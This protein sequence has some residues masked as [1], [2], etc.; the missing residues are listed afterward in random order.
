MSLPRLSPPVRGSRR[1]VFRRVSSLILLAAATT[2]ARADSTVEFPVIE[3]FDGRTN[4]TLTNDGWLIG[5]NATAVSDA[6]RLTQAVNAQAGTIIYDRAFS[7]SVGVNVQFDYYMGGGTGADGLAFFLIDGSATNPTP[8]GSGPAMGYA[9]YQ[10]SAGV[11]KGYLGVA[12]DLWGNFVSQDYF[13]DGL[14]AGVIPNSIAVR[15]PASLVPSGSSDNEYDYVV[16]S[17]V[18]YSVAGTKKVNL[19][20]KAD[21]TLSLRISGDN[22]T[23]W[24][25]IHDN[26]NFLATAAYSGYPL[27][28][29]FKLGFGASTGGSN[30]EHR[31]DNLVIR[32]PVDLRTTFTTAPSGTQVARTT[33]TYVIEATNLGPNADPA[34]TFA[35]TVPAHLTNVTWSAAYAGGASGAA[36][37]TGNTISQAINLPINGTATFTV[38]GTIADAAAGTTLNLSA[39]ATP[40]APFGDINDTNSTGTATTSVSPHPFVTDANISI[41]G[42][43]GTGGAYKIGDTV[44]AT[45]NNTAGGDNN[46]GITSVTVNFSAF[47]G[48]TTVAASNSSQT[49]TATYTLV[50]GAI[51]TTLANVSVTANNS[52]ISGTTTTADTTNAT[53]DTQAPIVSDGNLSI[54]GA[55]GTGGAYKI[56]DTV[57]ATWNNTA[58]GDNNADTISGVTVDFSAFGGGSAVAATSSSGT[59]TATYTLAAGAI[60][61][62]A[63]RNI[64]VT[65]TDNA[66][67][68]TTTADSSNATVDNVV[69][70]APSTPDLAAGSDSGAS[71]TDNI[72][73]VTTP[74]FTGT[75]ETGSTVRLYDTDGTTLLGSATATGGNWSI[76]SSALALGNHTVT[77]RTTDAAGNTSAASA[78]LSITIL[79]P[80]SV[81]GPT[82][83]NATVGVAFAANVLTTGSPTA[84]TATGLPA[85]L[86]I[87]ASTGAIS[88]TPTTAGNSTVT[89]GASHNGADATATLALTVAKGT[90]TVTLGNLSQNYTGTPRAATATT[91][92]ANLNV[93][94]TYDGSSTAPTDN[95]SYAVVATVNDA[96]YTGQATGTLNITSVSQTVSFVAPASVT[97]RTPVAL[98]A[99]A[100]SGLPVTFAVIAGDATVSGS[101][102]TVNSAASAIGLRATQAGNASYAAASADVTINLAAINKLDQA[103]TF[104]PL[105]DKL[106]NDAAF[107]L[108]ATASSGLPVTFTVVSGPAL[109]NGRTVTVTGAT[110]LVTVR[111]DQAGND[112]F[113]AAP[114]V[115]RTFNV[116]QVGPL[117]Y[118]GTTSE[119][120]DFAANLPLGTDT[121][122]L[123]GR[124][125]QTSRYFILTFRINPDR[126]ITGISLRLLG[127]D[128]TASA[129]TPDPV[130]AAADKSS[131]LIGRTGAA[132]LA[133]TFTGTVQNGVLSFSIAEL[134]VTLSGVIEP[135]AG[136]TRP[137][138][139]LYESSS[140]NSAN[141][142]T[143][144]IVG[145]TGKVYVLAITPN[146]VTGGAGTVRT[147]GT[148]A[149]GTTENATIVGDVDA[150]S[151]T[152]TGTIILPDGT[153]EDFA[154][155]STGTLRTD[156]MINL[157]T[158][159][160]VAA[161]E[162]TGNLIAGF[163]VGGPNPKPILIR[164]IGPG[165]AAYGVSDALA[166]PRLRLYDASGALLQENDNWGGTA[167]LAA[168]TSRVGGFPLAAGGKDAALLMTL[169]PGAYTVHVIHSGPAGVALAE[170][171]DASENPNSE[172]QRLINI[173][174][175]GAVT[176]GDGVLIGGFVVTGNSPKRVLLRGVG[177]GL[178]AYGVDGTLADPTLKIFGPGGALIAQNDNW[179]TPLTVAGGQVAA[180]A[181][182]ITSS[183]T[184]T[185]A[186]QLAA[187]S[188]D[189]AVVVVLAPGAYTAHVG[190]A[191]T[192][193]GTALIEI[194]EIP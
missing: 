149:L 63:N 80:V 108:A 89:L 172:Y 95:G 173:S 191:S 44:T 175:R 194:Y 118:F 189:A 36:S 55:S 144:S 87:N 115:T 34:A 35:F 151:T 161:A 57:T 176:G 123:F 127:G 49:W 137:I 70:A 81:T 132:E 184:A 8:G 24:T 33:V 90:A 154:G 117:V 43:S 86:T 166:D 28:E 152:V 174:S 169:A 46:S 171:Y 109:I 178:G 96:N 141:G 94:L 4:T 59:W 45:W 180:T 162:G 101:T 182:E 148:F 97:V 20:V 42:A 18:N 19:T 156:R 192:A 102:L 126:T 91:S 72:T 32:K 110:G 183:N 75:A 106:A 111:A 114:S 107:D 179:Q 120:A 136:P 100:S 187:G 2:L 177:P 188:K 163:V 128:V 193:A 79:S 147:D 54:S 61:G 140:L 13:H 150:P 50:A 104:D 17:R 23:T 71:S 167:A 53:V 145:T 64:S 131:A 74:T 125:V 157:S 66:G 58:G 146:L 10:S 112:V 139:G 62:V 135:P 93:V 85:G 60:N 121:G 130:R 41:S 159:A 1:S 83:G 15:G 51:D 181:A 6:L 186:F 30:N 142:T 185:G 129:P 170:V 124:I 160:K 76:T 47:G 26:F 29:T 77:A 82:T 190:S 14:Q 168:A 134:G 143:T 56:G 3:N 9:Y 31:V 138:A 40:S 39:A 12:F 99:T 119:G 52:T 153:E 88:G 164:G 38:S 78:G 48:G 69:P 27:P 22:G 122:T 37:G 105:A 113:N 165:L 84:Y 92:P 155:L 158:R 16:G 7:S 5:G 133:Y 11:T 21:G 67:N 103:I 65:A 98:T 68:T 73:I 25:T 116:S